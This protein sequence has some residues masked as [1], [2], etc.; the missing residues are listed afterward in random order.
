MAQIQGVECGVL[1]NR[2]NG[3]GINAYVELH[4]TIHKETPE[5]L[6]PSD[7]SSVMSIKSI[8]APL[9]NLP[10]EKQPN[11]EI[12][13]DKNEEGEDLVSIL[14]E[15]VQ[16]D[17]S[18]TSLQTKIDVIEGEKIQNILNTLEEY[19]PEATTVEERQSIEKL[20]T[21]NHTLKE[22]RQE[23]PFRD[24]VA[25]DRLSTEFNPFLRRKKF[26]NNL[27][28]LLYI[29]QWYTSSEFNAGKRPDGEVEEEAPTDGRKL[30]PRR[31]PKQVSPEPEKVEEEKP[32]TKRRRTKAAVK[33]ETPESKDL[34]DKYNPFD[35]ENILEDTFLPL[36]GRQAFANSIYKDTPSLP[37]LVT[38]VEPKLSASVDTSA[39]N[40]IT[41]HTKHYKNLPGSFPTLF[42]TNSDGQEVVNVNNRI[43]IRFLLYPMH[44]EE[45]V[46]AQPKSNQLDPVDEIIKFFQV[47]YGLYFSGSTKI[48]N[49][50]VTNYCQKLRE[51]V[52]DDDFS[53]FV[54]I[55]D[56]W[57]Q[58]VLHLSPNTSL[59]SDIN[60]EIRMYTKKNEE[61]FSESDLK[62]SIFHKEIAKLVAKHQV[63][64]SKHDKNESNETNG[65][66]DLNELSDSN[67]SLFGDSKSK[68]K[69]DFFR[70]LAS[71]Q[72]ISRYA[73]H[74]I[75]SR[76]YARVVSISSNKL[77]YYKAFT[78]EV[79]GELLP[80]FTS[81]V[82]T[83]V[84][85]KPHHKFYDLGSGVG[86]TTLQ[87][88]LEFGAA[89][90]GG[91]ELMAHASK[92]T[93]EQS[94]MV[95]RNLSVFGL[96]Q[97]N[98]EWALLQSFADNEQV[99]RTVIDCDILIVNNYLFDAELNY[100]VGK[101]LYGL[102]PGSKI[103]SLRNFIS[104]RYKASFDDTIFDYLQVEKHEMEHNMSVSW[105]ANKVPYYIS[106]VQKEVCKQYL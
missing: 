25:V 14:K 15:M 22:I 5:P 86:N 20:A 57:N 74:Q 8:V 51:A 101:L 29:S 65:T 89:L 81:E 98:L 17:L 90:S 94:N 49:I 70:Q 83:K 33:D 63:D 18:M 75:L 40:L 30:R 50:I 3:V 24:D 62:I 23:H 84:G 31:K 9:Q 55:I 54:S 88:A 37:P 2:P 95:Q 85:M 4:H 46:L 76:V 91:C 92:L 47:N 45:Y 103:V 79:Y 34:G 73:L 21:S 71:N 35:P 104:P 43:R 12:P 80:C 36:H 69:R 26:K 56:K 72:K 27:D 1:P 102:R 58:M 82:L 105:T 99:R 64:P 106:V 53:S 13:T 97:L 61:S 100:K 68:Y 39:S 38:K 52:D 6:T 28:R 87:A 96:K 19:D 11:G 60:P 78:A 77:R 93:L 10:E 66:N 42:V 32:R 44:C 59:W 48:R 7:T 16:V 41:Q 67:G